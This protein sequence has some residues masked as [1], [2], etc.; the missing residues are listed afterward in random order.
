M[1]AQRR[2]V[3][4]M[5]ARHA[6][7]VCLVLCVRIGPV[8]SRS[9]RRKGAFRSCWSWMYDLEAIEK[10]VLWVRLTT[11]RDESKRRVQG[12]GET[13]KHDVGVDDY[14]KRTK[15]V[16]QVS[17]ELPNLRCACAC[18][19]LCFWQEVQGIKVKSAA[20]RLPPLGA[21]MD[22]EE[23]RSLSGVQLA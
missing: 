3:G 11:R 5:Q 23:D 8:T 1:L 14:V 19:C 4:L 20:A 13:E 15:P 10:G 16:S 22:R 17:E 12:K 9:S 7:S 6:I 18:A 21:E 2:V